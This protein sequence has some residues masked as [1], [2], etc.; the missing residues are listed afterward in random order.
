MD[1][2]RGQ[3]R[4]W[5]GVCLVKGNDLSKNDSPCLHST[6]NKQPSYLEHF[7]QLYDD[8]VIQD[9]LWMDSHFILADKYL[10]AM[11]YTYF[12][13]ADLSRHEYTR[14][15]FFVALELAH[16]MEEDNENLRI[17]IY[18]WILGATW[19]TT[20]PNF[21]RQRDILLQRMDF[22]AVVS[23]QTCEEIIGLFP[24]HP[25][26]NRVR[27]VGQSGISGSKSKESS[28]GRSN[29]FESLC[30]EEKYGISS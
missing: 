4:S 11:I 18:S 29:L 12:R 1:V 7:F 14:I 30:S 23:R 16:N 21:I 20:Y 9:F 2:D 6:L 8:D 19:K 15:N 24:S 13:R 25:I 27:T 5:N 22:R 10:L 28:H 26:W 17:E 3:K